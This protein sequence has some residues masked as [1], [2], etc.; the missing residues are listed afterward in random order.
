[1]SAAST[2][3][4]AVLAAVAAA[5][6][7][8]SAAA[9]PSAPA[10][11]VLED[12]YGRSVELRIG[13]GRPVVV[14]ASNVRDAAE[15]IAAWSEA[16][17]GLPAEVEVYRIADL[18]ALPF[19]VPRGAVAKDLKDKHPDMPLLLDWKGD[20]SARLKAPKKTTSVLVFGPDGTEAGRVAGTA[21]LSG[22]Y[23]VKEIVARLK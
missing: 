11:S 22:A 2:I 14:I 9:A 4:R 15:Q 13:E 17:A 1:M 3:R 20:V 16:L 12:Q 18:K 21:G 5:F 19:F 10:A 23:T 6:F 8:S 7:A